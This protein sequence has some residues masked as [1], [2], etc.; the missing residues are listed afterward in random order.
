MGKWWWWTGVAVVVGFTVVACGGDATS[1][2]R[3]PTNGAG[4]AAIGSGGAASGGSGTD[5]S[6][7]LVDGS[8]ASTCV[9]GRIV[10]AFGCCGEAALVRCRPEVSGV[11]CVPRG[12]RC[13]TGEDAPHFEC[14]EGKVTSVPGSITAGEFLVRCD[15]TVSGV[16]CVPQGQQCPVPD[17]G[18]RVDSEGGPPD[19]GPHLDSGQAPAP[20]GGSR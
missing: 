9:N 14:V 3:E 15:V 1:Q 6:G 8:L 7:G 4:G 19:A 20:D 18:G 12:Q 5:G 11:E 13:S 16:A 10:T 17:G 2:A